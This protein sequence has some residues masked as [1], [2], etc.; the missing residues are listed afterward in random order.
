MTNRA[1]AA[2]RPFCRYLNKLE[3]YYLLLNCPVKHI[4]VAVAGAFPLENKMD[5]DWKKGKKWLIAETTL[6]GFQIGKTRVRVRK[7]DAGEL[8][9]AS[10][11]ENLIFDANSYRAHSNF[12]DYFAEN[13]KA[14]AV[15]HHGQ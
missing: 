11:G 5:F 12:A 13:W 7:P 1:I 8:R 10:R 15:I 14:S 6:A 2:T 9:S 3:S 4:T